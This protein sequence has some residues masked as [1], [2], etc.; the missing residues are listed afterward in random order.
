MRH[1]V[2]TGT[3]GATIC[4]FDPAAL[5]PDFDE[6]IEDDPVGT[7]EAL[8]GE[9]RFWWRSTDGDGAYLFHFYV[10]EDVPEP[11]STQAHDGA[12]VARFLVPSGVIWACGAEYAAR[13]PERG[14][15]GTP[16]GGL[17]RYAHM[18]GRF[19]LARGAYSLKAWR[20]EWPERTRRQEL[21]RRV[22]KA[23]VS[24]LNR[25]ATVTGVLF[26]CLLALSVVASVLTL[27]ALVATLLGR[28]G[29]GISVLLWFLGT[30]LALWA[31][32]WPLMRWTTRMERNPVRRQAEREFPSL[33]IQMRRIS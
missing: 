17:E 3:D 26:F 27:G 25:L 14:H 8:E 28:R 11:I 31:L 24:H 16:K 5:P 2:E 13:D 12:T 23:A 22:G 18:G 15:A 32:C 30:L 9:G 29:L 1:V 10:D 6:R 19:E 7:F 21:E 33:V 20:A 4:F